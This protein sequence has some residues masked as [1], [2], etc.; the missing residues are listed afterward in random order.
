MDHRVVDH[1]DMDHRDVDHGDMVNEVWMADLPATWIVVTNA[2]GLCP[3]VWLPAVRVMS[4][5]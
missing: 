2:G 5:L 3:L 1:W 4:Q